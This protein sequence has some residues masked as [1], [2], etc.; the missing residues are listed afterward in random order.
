LLESLER[1]NETLSIVFV[2]AE[3]MQG[4]N[5]QYLNRDYPTDV[6]SFAYGAEEMDGLPFLGEI[7]VSPEAAIKQAVS[8]CIPPEIE[9]RTL[10]AHGTLHLLGYDHETDKGEMMRLQKMLSRRKFFVAD[11]P[12][13]QLKANR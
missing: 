3:E 10:L 5:R 4:L 6:L 7:F 12:L 9:I 13:L 11:P 8:R 1:Q 2:G